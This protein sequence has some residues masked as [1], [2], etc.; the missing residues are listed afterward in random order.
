MTRH[1]E[2]E[3]KEKARC[4][5]KQELP[6]F[7][8]V[9]CSARL[10]EI[11]ITWRKPIIKKAEQT[12]SQS[13]KTRRLATDDHRL[14]KKRNKQRHNLATD[15]GLRQMTKEGSFTHCSR[16]NR[17]QLEWAWSAS[18]TILGDYQNSCT[19]EFAAAV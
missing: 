4:V 10:E 7:I 15:V 19:G 5:N 2:T 9:L 13:G 3:G 17:L 8:L 12:A 11:T 16:S 14:S 1:P 6:R 18:T